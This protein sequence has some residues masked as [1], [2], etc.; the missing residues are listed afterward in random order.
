MVR[1]AWL[2]AAFTRLARRSDNNPKLELRPQSTRSSSM[3]VAPFVPLPLIPPLPPRLTGLSF[4][5]KE[6]VVKKQV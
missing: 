2:T 6:A 5:C 4:Q 3:E 1:V